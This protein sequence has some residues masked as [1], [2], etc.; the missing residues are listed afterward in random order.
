MPVKT[1]C[2]FHEFVIMSD[3]CDIVKMIIT[4]EML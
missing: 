4:I 2:Y 1:K 3:K